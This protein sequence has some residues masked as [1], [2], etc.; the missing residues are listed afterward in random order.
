[1]DS[2]RQ[3]A[4]VGATVVVVLLVLGW[5]LTTGIGGLLDWVWRILVVGLL[6]DISITLKSRRK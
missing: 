4:V 3:I 6:V 5:A 1:M 2:T